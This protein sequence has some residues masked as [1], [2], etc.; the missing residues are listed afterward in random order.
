MTNKSNGIFFTTKALKV[1]NDDYKDLNSKYEKKQN[2][3]VKEVIAIAGR[4]LLRLCCA[5]ALIRIDSVVLHCSREAQYRT[6]SFGRRRK[7]STVLS[8]P[9]HPLTTSCSLAVAANN[10]PIPYVKPEVFAKGSGSLNL[11]ES[12]HPCLEVL[13]GINFIPN[14]VTLERGEFARSER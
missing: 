2:S 4:P 13:E 9:N 10:A 12:R 3:L 6:R 11:V 8:Q 14:D 7:V 1:L 5:L